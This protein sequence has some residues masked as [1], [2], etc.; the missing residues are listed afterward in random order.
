MDT[1]KLIQKERDNINTHCFALGSTFIFWKSFDRE[2]YA[3]SF[4]LFRK[5]F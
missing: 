1:K 2:A 4:H 5:L 3:D